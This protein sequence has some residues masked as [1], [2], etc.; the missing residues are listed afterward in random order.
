LYNF[1]KALLSSFDSE[2]ITLDGATLRRLMHQSAK[3]GIENYQKLE[4]DCIKAFAL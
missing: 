1:K 2:E 3:F 4:K